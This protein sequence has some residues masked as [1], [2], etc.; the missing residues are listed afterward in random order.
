MIKG[1]AKAFCYL[2]VCVSGDA[3]V[4]KTSLTRR[5]VDEA[6]EIS[7]VHTIGLD[8]H[9]KVL[10]LD[11]PLES[12]NPEKVRLQIWDTAGQ[13]RSEIGRLIS[14]RSTILSV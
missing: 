12:D 3:G 10:N 6:F 13:E 8:F 5:F 4:G 2:S 11:T 14:S 1:G 9:E 7:Y